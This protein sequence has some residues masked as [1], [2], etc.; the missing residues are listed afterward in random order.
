MKTVLKVALG[1]LL[2][3][4]V[5]IV[6]CVAVIGAGVDSADKEQKKR[7]ITLGQFKAQKAGVAESDVRAELGKPDD[8]Q[9]F[10][11]A[12]VKGIADPSKSSCIYYPEKGK[13]IGDGRSFQLCFTNGKL[14]SKNVY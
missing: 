10:E 2:G 6:G 7:G 8:A 1:V 5:L 9:Q 14:D 11:D 12:G 3:V 4:T 13:G